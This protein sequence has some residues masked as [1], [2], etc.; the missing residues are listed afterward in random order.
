MANALIENGGYR[1]WSDDFDLKAAYDDCKDVFDGIV[2][3]R[4]YQECDTGLI[5]YHALEIMCALSV[6]I[7]MNA[8]K[9]DE[10][11]YEYHYDHT[12]C[13]WYR[14]KARNR[15]PSTCAQYRDGWNDAMNYFFRDGKGYRPFRR[16]EHYE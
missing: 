7:G 5:L 4:A 16:D 10:S 13:I 2:S 11:K 9:P 6:V 15:C 12:D 3:D 8:I 14:P 1:F